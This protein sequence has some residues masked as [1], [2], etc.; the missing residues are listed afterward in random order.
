MSRQLVVDLINNGDNILDD[1]F[2]VYWTVLVGWTRVYKLFALGSNQPRSGKKLAVLGIVRLANKT[3]HI[4]PLPTS[5]VYCPFALGRRVAK[6]TM[7]HIW[8][9]LRPGGKSPVCH[10]CH[11]MPRGQMRLL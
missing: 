5:Q 11:I 8:S 3:L 2:V 1:L 7:W 9:Q 10:I 4:Q 6:P